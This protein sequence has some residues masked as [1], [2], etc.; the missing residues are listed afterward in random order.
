MCSKQDDLG[1]ARVVTLVAVTQAK[2]REA[3]KAGKKP[4][5]MKKSDVKKAELLEKYRALADAGRGRLEAALAKRRK[6]NA[7]KDHRYVPSSR[8]GADGS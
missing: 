8:R 6:K 5:Y 1:I 4:F 7:S 2:E 3:V